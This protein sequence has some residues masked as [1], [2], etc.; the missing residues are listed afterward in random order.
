MNENDLLFSLNEYNYNPLNDALFKFIFGKEERKQITIDFLNAVLEPELNHAIK[1]LAFANT[2]QSPAYAN[3]K[4][5]RLD[6]TCILDTNEQVD[7]EVQ[8]NNHGD[9]PK[10][11]LFYWAQMY[12]TSLPAGKTY[13][14]LKPAITINLTNFSFLSGEDF[15]SVY[16]IYNTKTGEPLTKDLSIHFLEIP[17]FNKQ[18]QKPISEMSKIERWLSYFTNRLNKI[19]KE[20]LAMSEAAIKNAMEAARIF[21]CNTEERRQYI[22]QE[23][24]RMD[25]AL[26]EKRLREAERKIA[27]AERKAAEAERKAAEE[28]ARMSALLQKLFQEEKINEIRAIAENPS[29][30]KEYYKKYGL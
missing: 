22:N 15:H 30:K 28:S 21:L 3:N 7:I 27:E 8:V 26:R 16:G 11:T 24:S 6:I 29:L 1:D 13:D 5:T 4:G 14:N 17:K 20:E 12:L 9:M 2:E 18:A 19:E 23:M 10:R 25:E